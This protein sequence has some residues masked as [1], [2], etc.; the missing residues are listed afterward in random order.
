MLLALA[1]FFISQKYEPI[2]AVRFAWWGAEELGLKGSTHYVNDLVSR[3]LT[4]DVA[5]Y[6]NFDMIA[7][8][9]YKV[10]IYSAE[11]APEAVKA[12][13]AALE[14]LLGDTL[15]NMSVTPVPLEF[16]GRSDYGPFVEAGIP[17]NGV[18]VRICPRF[19]F[20][21]VFGFAEF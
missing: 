19:P 20:L 15:R 6:L 9:N 5:L 2:N 7:S 4:S 3:D 1:R 11:M 13:V 10:G 17:A 18:E 8:P 21:V 14:G 16:N 12:G